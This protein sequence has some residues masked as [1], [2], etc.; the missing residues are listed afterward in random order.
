MQCMSIISTTH[1]ELYLLETNHKESMNHWESIVN[2]ALCRY[3]LVSNHKYRHMYK[4]RNKKSSY[5][6]S[7]LHPFRRFRHYCL[8]TRMIE[9][10][11][12]NHHGL[13]LN[14]ETK[15][16]KEQ[17]KHFLGFSRFNESKRK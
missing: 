5:R 10:R 6:L 2:I 8:V 4:S 17:R 16:T 11:K 14:S 1:Y 12:Y 3:K 9:R 7:L 13:E 15:Q